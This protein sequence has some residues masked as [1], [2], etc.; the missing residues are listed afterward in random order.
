MRKHVFA[1]RRHPRT[2]LAPAAVQRLDQPLGPAAVHHIDQLP[3][4]PIADAQRPAGA[5]NRSFARDRLEQIR[6]ARPERDF[7]TA[8]NL[9]FQ[10]EGFG[11]FHVASAR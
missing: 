5:R 7:V 10:F 4:P 8:Q 6:L 11:S 1:E 2:A 3:R 9:H